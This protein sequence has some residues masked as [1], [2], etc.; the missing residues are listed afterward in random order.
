MDV[1]FPL[2]A[3]VRFLETESEPDKALALREFLKAARAR[4]KEVTTRDYIDPANSTLDYVLLFIP[5]E[6]VY[7]F[8]HEKDPALLDEALQQ[9][10]VLCS[11]CT[12][13]AVLVV[14][15]QSISNFHL[16][17]QTDEILRTLGGFT[18]QWTK[19]KGSMETVGS[20]FESTQK[21]FRD[22]VG[23]RRR[24]L[25]RQVDRVELAP[26]DD[27]LIPS[28]EHVAL[29]EGDFKTIEAEESS[30]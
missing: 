1:K 24:A 20:R 14:I 29:R 6:Q 2:N 30:T 12:L 19:F 8:I 16:T 9:R 21:A 23:V 25:D 7:G 17:Q 15:R 11:P 3:Y 4:V 28:V 27:P 5:N 13:F 22:L 26:V 10:V 18:Q